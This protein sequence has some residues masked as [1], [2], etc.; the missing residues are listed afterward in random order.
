MRKNKF[1]GKDDKEGDDRF[2]PEELDLVEEDD[3][4]THE[5][6]LDDPELGSKQNTQQEVDVFKFDPNFSRNE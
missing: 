3:R 4:V 5:V 1:R 6:N 2:V